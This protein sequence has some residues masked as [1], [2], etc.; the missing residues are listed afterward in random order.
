LLLGCD[1]R[2]GADVDAKIGL[3]EVAIGMVLPDWAITIAAER[4]SRRH[5]QRAI[6]NARV[7]SPATPPP[8]G[9]STRWW[10]PTRCSTPPSTRAAELA[11]ALD[12]RAYAGTVRALRTPVLDAMADQIAAD[13]AGGVTP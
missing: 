10:R 4:L 11:G 6:A 2:V 3:N 13:R 5:L 8:S 1:V 12:A 7:T 9:S